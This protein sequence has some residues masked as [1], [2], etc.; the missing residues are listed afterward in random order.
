MSP[1]ILFLCLVCAAALD[2]LAQNRFVLND[3]TNDRLWILYDVDGNGLIDDPAEIAPFFDAGNAAG[4]L[5][6]M[7]PTCLAS[8]C[9]GLVLMGDQLNQ[10]VYTL[11]D[12]N[13]DG[14]ALDLGE[15]LVAA[16]AGNA[17][18][19]NFAF[20]T[21]AAVDATGRLY[22]VNS[23]NASGNDAV[24]RL[25]DLTADGDFQDPGEIAEIVGVGAFGAPNGAAS[26]QELV[27]D[28]AG[29]GYLRDSATSLAG[30]YRF[31]DLNSNGRADDPGEFTVFVNTTNAS[32]VTVAP[33]FALEPDAVRPRAYYTLQIVP[34]GVDQLLRATDVNGDGDAQDAGEVVLAYSTAE[35]S[36]TA[37]DVVSLDDGRVLITDNSGNIVVV[38]L[39]LDSDGTFFG[40]GE[41]ATYAD[42]G[43][44]QLAAARQL[45]RLP[46]RRDGDANCDGSIDILDINAFVFALSDPSGYMAAYPSCNIQNADVNR[47]CN[48]DVL[49]I[50]PFIA[51]L[52]GGARM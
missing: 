39:D 37:V 22:I 35:A 5:G 49:D 1:R 52:A 36:F 26:P 8:R 13:G 29:F 45:A 48:I 41:R 23:G 34:T 15:S 17:S 27:F 25:T 40:A 43:S 19:V 11:I 51:L 24:Y 32:G 4:T 42:N 30:I 10:A 16:Q 18:G 12:N 7:N 20:P 3:R 33:G 2:A 47:D 6:P 38:L 14:D 28:A 9:D 50:N 44:A 21:G 46:L 31:I